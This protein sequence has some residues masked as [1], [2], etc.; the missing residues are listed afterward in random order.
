MME[1]LVVIFCI[2]I[3]LLLLAIF[4]ELLNIRDLLLLEVLDDEGSVRDS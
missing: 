4:D 1:I 3:I 2:I